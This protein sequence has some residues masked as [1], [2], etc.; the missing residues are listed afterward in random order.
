MSVFYGNRKITTID[1]I[2]SGLIRYEGYLDYVKD[3][4]RDYKSSVKSRKYY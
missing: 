1:P 3:I 4:E 2:G